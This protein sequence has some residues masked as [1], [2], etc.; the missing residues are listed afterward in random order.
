MLNILADTFFET[1]IFWIIVWLVVFVAAL[2]TELATEQLVS[3]WFCVGAVVSGILAACKVEFIVQIIVFVAVSV[4]ILVI[5]K[6]TF[7]KNLN[8]RNQKTNYD[9]IIGEE[10]LITE[11]VVPKGIGAGKVRDVVWTVVSDNEIEAGEF[12]VV[13]EIRGNKLVVEKKN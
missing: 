7:A 9:A 10:I 8:G 6:T 5:A 4:A 2:G 11:T 3:V 13:K 12:A 1:R